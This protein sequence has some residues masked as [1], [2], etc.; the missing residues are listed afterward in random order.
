MQDV[1]T[2]ERIVWVADDRLVLLAPLERIEV[3]DDIV[4]QV[5][6]VGPER[7]PPRRLV[8]GD[9]VESRSWTGVYRKRDRRVEDRSGADVG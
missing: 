6:V 1:D 2:A 3:Q 8:T 7:R 5:V 9:D 4:G